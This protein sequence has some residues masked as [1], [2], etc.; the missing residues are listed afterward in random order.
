MEI[1]TMRLAELQPAEY[2]PR[3]DLQPGDPEY[4]KL[5]RSIQTFGYVEPI[6]W[7]AQT[8]QVV[9][10][11][12]RLKV[13][14]DLGVHE[15]KVVV[16]DL[17]PDDERALNIALNKISGDWDMPRLRDVLEG[18]DIDAYD[19]TLSGFDTDE[20]RD[21]IAQYSSGEEADDEDEGAWGEVGE[22]RSPNAAMFMSSAGST[23]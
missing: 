16:V 3:K 21:I 13:L 20:I 4:D 8:N 22:D 15:E 5:Y 9:G 23:A 6:I 18:L 17:P 10:G 12:Q 7:N 14:L 1:K 2:N 19:M 11:H